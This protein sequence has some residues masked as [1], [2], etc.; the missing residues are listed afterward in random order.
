[1]KVIIC[2]AGQVGHN[3]ARSLVRE[4]NDIT[5]IDQSEDLI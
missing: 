2:G 3:I 4:E 5:V 1:M